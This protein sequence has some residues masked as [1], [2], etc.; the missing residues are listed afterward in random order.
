MDR[1]VWQATVHGD[2]KSWHT[3]IN[4]CGGT[5]VF[6]TLQKKKLRQRKVKEVEFLHLVSS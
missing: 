4:L 1:G 5:I 2:A 3:P 6:S